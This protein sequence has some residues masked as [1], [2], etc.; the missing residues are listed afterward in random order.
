VNTPTVR[1]VTDSACDLPQHV[2]DELGITIVPL[3]IRIDG[4][5]YTDRVDL[6]PAEFWARCAASSTLPETAAPAPGQFEQEYRRLAAEGAT[7]IVVVSLSGAGSNIGIYIT[8][9]SSTIAGNV[10][11]VA[12]S[13]IMVRAQLR[14]AIEPA[15]REDMQIVTLFAT[16]PHLPRM[17]VA[18]PLSLP[19]RPRCDLGALA[20]RS[21]TFISS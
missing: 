12:G 1:F 6:S 20:A 11:D 5:E 19:C 2:A 3:T 7:A 16:C 10:V 17:P 18:Y 21:V 9:G 15:P 13:A 4:V 14:S 8:E